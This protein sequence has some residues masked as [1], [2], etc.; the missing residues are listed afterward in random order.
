M[1]KVG[2]VVFILIFFVSSNVFAQGGLNNKRISL[3]A[4]SVVQ[5]IALDED[6][7]A[8]SGGSGTIIDK[9]G[10]IYTNRHVLFA[11]DQLA[12]DYAI[13]ITEDM[14]ETPTHEY[15]ASVVGAS[16]F[17][18]FAVLQIDRDQKGRS[19]DPDDLDLPYIANANGD[20]S[21]GEHIYTFGYP[22]IG[23]GYIVVTQ[24]T[25]TT[26]EN[27][28][29][30]EE[31]LPVWYQTD[32]EISPGNSGGLAVNNEGEFIGIPS[33]VQAENTTGGRLGGILP[34]TAID[35][36]LNVE[37][38]LVSLDELA[39]LIGGSNSSLVGGVS[40]DCGRFGTFDNGIEVTVIQM[41]SGFSYTATA[42]GLNG[43]DPILAVLNTDTGDGTC[44]DNEP[45]ATYYAVDLPT[46]GLTSPSDSTAQLQFSQN[47]GAGMAD[48]SLVV[49]GVD[50]MPGEFVLILEGMAVTGA[51]G[52]G[53][54]FEIQV[55]PGM[56]GFGVPLTV[57]Q[58]ATTN[59]LDTYT[60]L[61]YL[62]DDRWNYYFDDDGN[63]IYY[64]DDAGTDLCW[65]D[66][67]DLSDSAVAQANQRVL[68]G[69]GYDSMIQIPL[70]DQGF[71]EFLA[72]GL[73][74]DFLMSSA[75]NTTGNYTVVIHAGTQ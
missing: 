3:I 49:G 12:S 67:L 56:V 44:V 7:Q 61:A 58:I 54:P 24:G 73:W 43:F 60:S 75:Q 4:Q 36:T 72:D 11:G 8:V 25:I 27:G 15:Y 70:Q 46:T 19:I 52:A 34:F 17:I 63:Q 35:A 51:D 22:G 40:V 41:R 5:V 66:S 28:D 62:E 37:D 18:D 26:I 59:D 38:G 9:T 1:K 64:C 20:V 14:S 53:D 74:F 23:E 33:A 16:P 57:Y 65:G 6:G 31:R 71:E 32:A 10:L 48:Q 2:F 69:G 30:G 13:Y 45:N 50:N 21:H 68:A 39:E 42:I 29:V 47:T 55:T